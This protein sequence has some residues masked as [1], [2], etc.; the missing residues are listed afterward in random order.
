LRAIANVVDR[1]NVYLV[2]KPGIMA[3]PKDFAATFK[4]KAIAGGFYGGTP[5][6]ITRYLCVKAGLSP[7]EDVK[8]VETTAAGALAAMKAGQVQFATVSEP[9]VTQGIR[10]GLWGEPFYNV[11][12]ALGPYAYSTLNVRKDSIDKNPEAV[13]GFARAV[14]KGLEFTYAHPDEAAAIAKL[15]FPT[16]P[17]EDLRA[18][19]DRSFADEMW[20]RKGFVS[21]PAWTTAKSVVMAAGLLKEDV[22]YDAIID[23][24]FVDKA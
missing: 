19:L 10:A 15:E 20:S 17:L 1:G 8:I 21:E 5:N 24:S 7:A 6:S 2:A 14:I 3:D 9:Q 16:M 4:G 11:P 18:T 12:K 23:M 13:A 22:P